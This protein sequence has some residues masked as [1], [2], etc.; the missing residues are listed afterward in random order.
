MPRLMRRTQWIMGASAALAAAGVTACGVVEHEPDMIAGKRAFVQKC[1]SCHQLAR[2][3]TK[4]IQGP[5]LDEAFRQSLADGMK[6]STIEGVVHRQILQPNR[7]AQHDPTTGK[8]LI[9]MPAKLV[10]GDLALDVSSYVA[11]VAAK[12]GKDEGRLADV[13]AAAAKGTATAKNGVLEIDADPTGQL[14]FAAAAAT[15]TAGSLDIKSVNKSGTPHDISVKG[16]G[17]DEHGKVVSNGGTS[18]VKLDLKPGRY[19]FY[20]SVPGHEAG[21]MKGTLTVKA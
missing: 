13:G 9:A 20:C 4:G 21:G 2:A 6:R 10:K 19:T 17:V 7:R 16:G 15:A 8:D 14:A 1:G 12:G 11:S 3:G 5:N 18:E